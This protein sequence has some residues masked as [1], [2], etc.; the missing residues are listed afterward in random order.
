LLALPLLPV[1]DISPAFDDIKALITTETTSKAQLDTLCRYVQKQWLQKANIGPSRLSVRDNTARTNNAVES[2]HAALRRRVQVAHPNLFAFLGHLHRMTKDT[3]T[4]IARLNRGMMIRRPKKRV[5]VVND[6]RIRNCIERYDK[7]VYT[8][9]QFLRAVSH[10][11]GGHSPALCDVNVN[12]ESEDDDVDVADEQQQ[13]RSDQD[14]DVDRDDGGLDDK[15]DVCLMN[16]RD[17][18]IALVPCGHQRFCSTCAAEVERQGR[19]CPVC[20]TPIQM[21]LR[22]Y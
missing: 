2:F 5:N 1:A 17:P 12:S 11:V 9:M 20:R 4:D 10:S 13:A 19:G 18:R 22:L 16:K 21:L 15:C 3:A 6:A 8:R 14:S 7:G